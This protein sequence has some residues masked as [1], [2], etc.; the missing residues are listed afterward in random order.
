MAVKEVNGK[1]YDRIPVRT[2]VIVRGE[3]IAKVVDDYT[4]DIRLPRDIIVVS[5]KATAASQGRAI[6]IESI[7]PG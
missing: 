3:D 1:Q 5:E 6:P 7:R 2:H 4:K